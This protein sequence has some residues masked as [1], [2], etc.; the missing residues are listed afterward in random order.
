MLTARYSHYSGHL[1]GHVP[2]HDGGRTI[3]SS[4]TP[5]VPISLNGARVDVHTAH[6]ASLTSQAIRHSLDSNK[7]GQPQDKPHELV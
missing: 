1:G 7:E 2:S 5:G 4:G 6:S 3:R